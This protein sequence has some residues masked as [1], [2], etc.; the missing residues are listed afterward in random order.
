MEYCSIIYHT[1]EDCAI[2]YHTIEYCSIIYQIELSPQN[3]TKD[4][5]VMNQ[6]RDPY[7]GRI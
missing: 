7:K 6:I 4:I 3:V 5:H 1:I 2:M